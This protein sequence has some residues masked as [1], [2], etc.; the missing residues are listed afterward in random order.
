M[1]SVGQIVYSKCGRDKG[2]LFIV[3]G[4]CD[5]YC[6]IADG[7][8]RKIETPKKKKVKHIQPTNSI[9]ELVSGRDS[10]KGLKDSDLKS[11]ISSFQSKGV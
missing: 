11:V 5:E 9:S 10:L 2:N 7:D 4:L 6:F 1:L 3:I 8:L